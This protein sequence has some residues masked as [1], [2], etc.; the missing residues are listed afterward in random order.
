MNETSPTVITTVISTITASIIAIFTLF[1]QITIVIYYIIRK[2][3]KVQVTKDGVN[4]ESSNSPE[5]LPPSLGPLPL[6]KN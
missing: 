6:S 2:C 1:L 4:I 5:G 3:K